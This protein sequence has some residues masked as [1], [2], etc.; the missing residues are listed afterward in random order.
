M[1]GNDTF[2]AYRLSK[3]VAAMCTSADHINEMMLQIVSGG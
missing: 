1:T 2:I 3:T